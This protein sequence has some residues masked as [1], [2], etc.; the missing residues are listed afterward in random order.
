MKTCTLINEFGF[1]PDVFISFSPEI[2]KFRR[3][4][5]SLKADYPVKYIGFIYSD[6]YYTQAD[7]NLASKSIVFIDACYHIGNYFGMNTGFVTDFYSKFNNICNQYGYK[8]CVKKH[9]ADNTRA[10]EKSG[11]T[12]IEEPEFI[13]NLSTYSIIAGDYSTLF[14]ILLGLKHTVGLCFNMFPDKTFN[15][16]KFLTSY[17]VSL[18]ISDF[19]QLVSLLKNDKDVLKTYQ[20]QLP[21]KANYVNEYL[22]KLDGKAKERFN[23]LLLE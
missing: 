19:S 2:F 17:K 12:I 3:K 22:F 14:L 10:I 8:L 16:V 9:P 13:E 11:V 23:Q 5:F 1:L 7:F 4:V 15:P 18:E 6:K 20:Q 21:N